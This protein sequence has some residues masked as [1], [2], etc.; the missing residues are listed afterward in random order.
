[1]I[2]NPFIFNPDDASVSA[3]RTRNTGS[4]GTQIVLGSRADDL[5][6]IEYP[7]IITPD[8][9]L[10]GTEDLEKIE[11]GRAGG[12]PPVYNKGDVHPFYTYIDDA[13]TV[14]AIRN[15]TCVY[16]GEH[17]C[18]WD[19]D[20][21]LTEEQA[22][23]F[24][25]E[26]DNHIYDIDTSAFGQGRFTEDGGK[27]QIL[28]QPYKDVYGFFRLRDLYATGEMSQKVVEYYGMNLDHAIIYITSEEV[29]RVCEKLL[30]TLAHEYQHLIV[31]SDCLIYN[32]VHMHLWLNEAMSAYAEEL[33]Y[34]GLKDEWM[35]QLAMFRSDNYRKGQS[36]YNFS[37]KD[38]PKIG[39]YGAVYLFSKYLSELAGKQVF[40]DVHN[41]Y[42]TA[43]KEEI[44]GVELIYRSV[45]E[46]VRDQ[47]DR[48]YTYPQF[49]E[50]SFDNEADLWMSKLT[51]DFF[52]STNTMQLAGSEK[53]GYTAQDVWD[54]SHSLMIY[55]EYSSQNIEGGGR[56]IV[57][58]ENGTFTI[59]KDAGKGLIFIGLDEKFR[60]VTGLFTAEGEN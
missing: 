30:G 9:L 17:C 55:S 47:I 29:D 20:G 46:K 15:F 56:M 16:S 12:V 37:Y 40:S 57:A 36:L 21:T 41:N 24:G 8:D 32:K 60:P 26:F 19:L 13:R 51:L 49:I 43:E 59:P 23:G 44:S 42:R 33:T 6:E 14:R 2:Y 25:T 4:I 38:D 48:K 50:E 3:Q 45:S 22:K 7:G 35:S 1:M 39:A 27:V 54:K 53:Y 10:E 28:F 52:L 5:D 34:P 11:D 18:I 58:L 31:G